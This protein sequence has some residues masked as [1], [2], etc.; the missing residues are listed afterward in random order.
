[1]ILEVIKVHS[2]EFV[3]AK[4]DSARVQLHEYG[5]CK[6]KETSLSEFMN[7]SRCKPMAYCGRG[8]ARRSIGM[9]TR[10]IALTLVWGKRSRHLSFS[11]YGIALL[12]Y[13]H[14]IYN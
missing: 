1:M 9:F 2:L 14:H 6:K 13:I 10:I 5:L 11:F 12:A 3:A 8:Y 4:A 7:C